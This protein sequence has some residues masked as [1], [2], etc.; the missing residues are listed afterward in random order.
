M[1]ATD[2]LPAKKQEKPPASLSLAVA[3]R[4]LP[5]SGIFGSA[6]GASV[7]FSTSLSPLSGHGPQ[8]FLRIKVEDTPD[9]VH[10]A[11]T[12]PVSAGMSMQEVLERAC[13]KTTVDHPE[14]YALLLANDNTR[15]LIP[16]DRTVASLQGKHELVLIRR[17]MIDDNVVRGTGKTTVSNASI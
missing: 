17:T 10:F 13:R 16:L 5:G 6:L 8:I 15:I 12:I 14:A 7:P 4:A 11:T 1:L 3:G 2:A 9:I